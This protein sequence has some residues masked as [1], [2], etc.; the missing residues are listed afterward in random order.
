[1]RWW[2]R[3]RTSRRSSGATR[4]AGFSEETRRRQLSFVTGSSEPAGP[5]TNA[6]GPAIFR[7][8][9]RS[10]TVC[11]HTPGYTQPAAATLDGRRSPTVL[12][13]T[14]IGKTVRP[15]LLAKVRSVQEN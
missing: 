11:G 9:T 12:I 15:T 8:K 14:Q 10:G 13:N 4:A 5:G 7:Y 6:A 1:M 3:P 2:P